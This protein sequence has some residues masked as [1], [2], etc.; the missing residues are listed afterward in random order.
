MIA[1]TALTA[2]WHPTMRLF[3]VSWRK[4]AFAKMSRV[5]QTM[6]AIMIAPMKCMFTWLAMLIGLARALHTTMNV[7]LG[8]NSG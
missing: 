6:H 7:S 4:Q 2:P 8:S 1:P 5:A 3:V